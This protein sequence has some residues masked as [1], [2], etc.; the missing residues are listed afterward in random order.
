MHYKTAIANSKEQKEKR[1]ALR[2][3]MTSAETVLWK[4]LKGRGT[5]KWKF[6]RQQSIGPFILDFYCP[7]LK[8]CVEVD[9]SSHDYKEEYD[10]Q[11]TTFLNEQGIYVIRFH[12]EQVWVDIDG[13]ISEI[14][15]VGE[16]ITS[17]NRQNTPDR[18]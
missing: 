3:N 18:T 5:G 10:E 12:N 9:G 15:R 1:K 8:L 7:E 4:A 11:R 16:E 6:R 2:N 17:S 14:I 13:I